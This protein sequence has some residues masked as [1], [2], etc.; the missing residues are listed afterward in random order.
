L[1]SAGSRSR[2]KKKTQKSIDVRRDPGRLA[3]PSRWILL[4]ILL[5]VVAT[6]ALYFPVNHH[7]F[8]NYDDDEYVTENVHVKAGLTGETL[9][10]ALTTY[11]AA[12]WHPLTWFSH[13][14]DYQLFQLDPAGHHDTNLL[15]HALNVAL[16]FWVL[17]QATGYPGRSLMVAALFALHPINVES[18]V[19]VAERKNLLSV[20][21][22]LLALDAYRWYARQPRVGRYA[23]VT[24]FYVLGLLSK[25]QVITLPFVL[26]LWDYWPLRRMAIRDEQSTDAS[27]PAA[28]FPQRSSSW[29]VKEKLPLFALSAA[30]AVITMRAQRLGGGINPDSGLLT[31]L[32]NAI[33]SYARYL[34]QAFWPTRLAPIYPYPVG[35]FKAWEVAAASLLLV[36]ITAL[37]IAGRRRYLLVGWFWFVGT[38]VP[39]I[40]LVQVGRQAMADRYAYLPFVGLFIMV[41]WGAADW[42]KQRHIPVAW[43]AGASVGVLLALAALTHRQIDFWGDNVRL[44]TH[45]LQVT[46]GNYLAEDNLGRALQAQGK[47]QDAMPHFARSAEIEPSYV[48]PYIHMGIYQHQQDDFQGALRQYQRVISLTG[49]DIAH[50]GEIRHEIFA[51]MA[52]AYNGLGDFVRARECLESAVSLNPDNAEVWTNLGI[53]AQKTGDVERTIQAYSHAVK[54]Q[55]T[56]RGY[57]LLARALQQAGRQQEAQAA[58]QQG[59]ALA[60]ET[61][62]VR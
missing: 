19:W 44:W 56:Q 58:V 2:N 57:Q 8:V 4:L 13:A 17:W 61:G 60:G 33:V 62:Q 16:L 36:A 38:L 47:P 26:L 29:L 27:G 39:M 9:A 37:A 28:T 5:V 55:P 1:A 20:L 42:A 45:T 35:S 52:S 24:L 3:Q 51:N 41:C 21:F 50:Y 43:Q 23:A 31:R 11:D 15:L 59:M 30:S 6:V 49:N 32:A 34:G 10:W 12:N 46:N 7:P 25:P 48:F 22:F 40:G 14:L 53:M 18:V 54:L